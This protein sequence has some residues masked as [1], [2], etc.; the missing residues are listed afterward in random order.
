MSFSHPLFFNKWGDLWT[1]ITLFI[2]IG[3]HS[4]IWTLGLFTRPGKENGIAGTGSGS[5]RCLRAGALRWEAA[6]RSEPGS[7][8]PEQ[9]GFTGKRLQLSSHGSCR[10]R[11]SANRHREQSRGR[12]SSHCPRLRQPEGTPS[13]GQRRRRGD[14]CTGCNSAFKSHQ[15]KT[16]WR[17][18]SSLEQ[19]SNRRNK[20]KALIYGARHPIRKARFYLRALL[21]KVQGTSLT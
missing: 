11:G 5:G 18:N 6:R 2:S 19:T 4:S 8:A 9:R 17:R 16:L 10:K 7:Q 12:V 21:C 1:I 3:M 13:P 15:R 14:S 20:T